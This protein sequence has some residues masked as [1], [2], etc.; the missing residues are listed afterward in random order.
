M[1]LLHADCELT[2][3]GAPGIHTRFLLRDRDTKYS[4]RFDQFFKDVGTQIVKAPIQAPDANAFAE[5]WVGSLKRECLNHFIY[6]GE[7]HLDHI[8]QEYA[9]YYNRCRPH[10]GKGNVLLRRSRQ[11]S[12]GGEVVCESRLGGLLR[13]YRRSAA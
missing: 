5:T 3:R 8:L 13:H 9:D 11:R 12:A 7:G 1:P 6:F 2:H 4:R 10:Q